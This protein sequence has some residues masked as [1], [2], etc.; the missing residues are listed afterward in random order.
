MIHLSHTTARSRR[1]KKQFIEDLENIFDWNF[2]T[3][4]F[5]F[6]ENKSNSILS[7]SKQAKNIR[8]LDIKCKHINTK[9]Q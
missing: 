6:G 8:Q 7:A 5:Y 1:S 2:D 4:H 9:Q 3:K